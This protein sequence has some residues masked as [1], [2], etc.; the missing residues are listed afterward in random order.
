MRQR[1][2]YGFGVS[3]SRESRVADA[4]FPSRVGP[5]I[6]FNIPKQETNNT[7]LGPRT[8]DHT[9]CEPRA[10]PSPDISSVRFQSASTARTFR[11]FRTN[12]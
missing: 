7:R 8:N 11:Y 2:Q 3:R 1:L 4:A 10:Q 9:G 5:V 12:G 6:V